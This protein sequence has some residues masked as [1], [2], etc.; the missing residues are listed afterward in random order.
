M[1]FILQF[2]DFSG[3][4]GIRHPLSK[5]GQLFSWKLSL[6]C[7]FKSKLNDTRLLRARQVL[8][9]VNY[10]CRRHTGNHS[11]SRAGAQMSF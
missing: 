2:L 3:I 7:Q 10:S 6:A 9:L 1:D 4:G 8:D 11:K 5:F